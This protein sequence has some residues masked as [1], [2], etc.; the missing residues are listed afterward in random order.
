VAAGLKKPV[1]VWALRHSFATHLLEAGKSIRV[2]QMLLRHRSLRTTQRNT[3]V[4]TKTVRAAESPLEV[5]AYTV[6]RDRF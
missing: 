5:L 6:D 1:T 2:I 4:S 3:Y